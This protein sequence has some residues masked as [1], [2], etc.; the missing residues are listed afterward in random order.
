GGGHM[1]GERIQELIGQQLEDTT[2]PPK[3]M[4]ADE[5]V[6]FAIT[7]Q[8]SDELEN[9][10]LVSDEVLKREPKHPLALHYAGVL[11]NQMRKITDAAA[12]IERSLTL[13]P[14]EADWHSNHG[15]VLQELG[16]FDEAIAAYN[17]AIALDAGHANAHS[18]L[19]VLL[20]ATGKPV[21][22]EAAY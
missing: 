3:E 8:R 20:R 13:V 21:D 2:A 14:R 9:A 7:L 17:R 15:I 6:D 5:V 4:T 16:R 10:K 22:A 1:F 18:N 19:G 11:H 12:L